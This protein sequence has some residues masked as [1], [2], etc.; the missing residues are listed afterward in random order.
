MLKSLHWLQLSGVYSRTNPKP[1]FLPYVQLFYCMCPGTLRPMPQ[2]NWPGQT[3]KQT[4]VPLVYHVEDRRKKSLNGG[5]GG[6]RREREQKEATQQKQNRWHRQ[7]I[8]GREK[9]RWRGW[10]GRQR[11]LEKGVLLY[12]SV[13]TFIN[14]LGEGLLKVWGCKY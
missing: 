14:V 9:G 2:R 13:C 11:R 5:Y 4:G 10:G 7:L 1:S 12:S 6:S 8:G 3:W